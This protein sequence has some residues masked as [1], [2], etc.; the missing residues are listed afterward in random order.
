MPQTKKRIGLMGCGVVADYGHLPA[1]KAV[2]DLD[3][4]ALYDPNPQTVQAAAQKFHVPHACTSLPEFF[5]HN[6]D[7]VAITSP[8]PAHLDNIRQCASHGLHVLCEKPLAMTDADVAQEIQ[9][10]QAAHKILATAFCY[11]F[12]PVSLKIKQLI[13][14]GAIGTPRS[15]RLIYL[16]NCHGKFRTSGSTKTLDPRWHGRMI[17]GGPMVDC[18]VHQI[19]LARFW[20]GPVAH[21]SAHGA[22]VNNEYSAPDHMYLHLDHTSGAHTLVEISYSYAHTAKD[23]FWQFSYE[24]IGTTGVIRFDRE[25][26]VFELR[27]ESQTLSLPF[28]H[29]K[30]F[31]GM[32]QAFAHALQ[33]GDLGPLPTAHDGLLA[34]QLARQATEHLEKSHHP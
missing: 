26:Q 29:E 12:S 5:S 25:R 13:D 20:I 9:L 30:N 11:R 17:E 8:A 22:W 18:G 28:D 15:L 19:D 3:L 16:W 6:L 1:I 14:E 21:S 27:N 7:A 33:T 32:Y 23:P 34:T 31:Q 4:V 10:M 24:I 2:D